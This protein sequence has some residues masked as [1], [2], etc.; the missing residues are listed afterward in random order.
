MRGFLIIIKQE[1]EKC[2]LTLTWLNAQD[3]M[4]CGVKEVNGHSLTLVNKEMGFLTPPDH[5]AKEQL[6]HEING[7]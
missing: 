1:T 7:G 6:E 4:Q 2:N 5:N 3:S